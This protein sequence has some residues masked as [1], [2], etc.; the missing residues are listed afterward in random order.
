M[1]LVFDL[2]NPFS[3]FVNIVGIVYIKIFEVFV[4]K[5]F[6]KISNFPIFFHF[7][8]IKRC[9]HM[10]L[11]TI[12]ITLEQP[13][14]LITDVVP[15][16][17]GQ[18]LFLMF[19]TIYPVQFIPRVSFN[20]CRFCSYTSTKIKNV[21]MIFDSC[22]YWNIVYEVIMYCTRYDRMRLIFMQ[23]D[24]FKFTPSFT[25][26]FFIWIGIYGYVVISVIL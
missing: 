2:I 9:F 14:T 6:I 11:T 24:I 10:S 8:Q 22:F 15:N 25:F 16:C 23:R 5:R 12:F 3:C 19:R 18:F 20:S 17:F 13:F 21:C 1:I 4:L 26:R 7:T